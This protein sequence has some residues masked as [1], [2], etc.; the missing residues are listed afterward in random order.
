MRLY[1][2]VTADEYELPLYVAESATELAS[3]L[4]CGKSNIYKGVKLENYRR[5]LG[6]KI[7]KTEIGDSIYE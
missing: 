7:I 5:R 2:A 6:C 1:I 3:F 4:G